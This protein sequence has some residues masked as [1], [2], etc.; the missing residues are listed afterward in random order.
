MSNF[1]NSINFNEEFLLSL[2][3]QLKQY[4]N[5]EGDYNNDSFLPLTSQNVAEKAKELEKILGD[6][7]KTNDEFKKFY[8]ALKTDHT[9]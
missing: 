5:N 4:V 8:K 3:A 1:G 9:R 7:R 2:P 6:E